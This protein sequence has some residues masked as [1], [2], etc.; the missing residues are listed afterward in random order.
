MYHDV[1]DNLIYLSPVLYDYKEIYQN[2][3]QNNLLYISNRS[4]SESGYW[5]KEKQQLNKKYISV[6]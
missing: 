3:F 6:I 4:T 1:I 5:Q 2:E